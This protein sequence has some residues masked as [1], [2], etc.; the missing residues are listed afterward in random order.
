M[1]SEIKYIHQSSGSRSGLVLDREP[2]KVLEMHVWPPLSLK[3][4]WRIRICIITKGLKILPL[5]FEQKTEGLSKRAFFSALNP[6]SARLRTHIS[7]S[8]FVHQPST[9][10]EI[11]IENLTFFVRKSVDL[12]NFK[13]YSEVIQYEIQFNLHWIETSLKTKC[14]RN[15]KFSFKDFFVRKMLISEKGRVN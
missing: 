11:F 9:K 14:A 7:K 1:Q 2:W 3:V 13:G 8:K 12:T 15:V 10:R 4:S 6:S 5:R